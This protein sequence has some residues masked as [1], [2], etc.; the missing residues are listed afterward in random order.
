MD[1]EGEPHFTAQHA[2][3]V[4]DHYYSTIAIVVITM[5][6]MMMMMCFDGNLPVFNRFIFFGKQI[7]G[8]SGL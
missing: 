8:T 5:I 1:R 7:F 2:S 6:M 4:Y 3:S